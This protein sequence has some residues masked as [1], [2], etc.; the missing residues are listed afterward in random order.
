[1]RCM[2]LP[3]QLGA[4]AS[5]NLRPLSTGFGHRHLPLRRHCSSRFRRPVGRPERSANVVHASSQV[6]L[7][8]TDSIGCMSPSLTVHIGLQGSASKSWVDANASKLRALPLVAG[9]SGII[10]VLLNRLLSGVSAFVICMRYIALRLSVAE[11]PLQ[12][13]MHSFASL[14]LQARLVLYMQVAPVVDASSSQS[15]TDVLVILLSA[16]LLLTGL[17]WLALRPKV[18]PSV[19]STCIH[20]TAPQ[21]AESFSCFLQLV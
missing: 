15:R 9:A 8:N 10:G 2:L 17:Q 6:S 13:S 7:S 1:M 11:Q 21:P 4:Q 20:C 19:S 12:H 5:A 18:K 14:S 3:V 16:V